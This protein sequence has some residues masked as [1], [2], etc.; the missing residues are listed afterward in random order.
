MFNFYYETYVEDRALVKKFSLK[1]LIYFVF[2]YLCVN[3][4][5]EVFVDTEE[6]G[7]YMAHKYGRKKYIILPVIV[8]DE[9]INSIAADKQKLAGN[10][11]VLYCGK[12][13]P[14]H[15][16]EK[17]IAAAEVLRNEPINFYLQGSGQTRKQ[18]E[19][20]VKT[21]GLGNKVFF[22]DR[23]SYEEM[24]ILMK[25]A[26]V[27]LGVFGSSE[28]TKRV[29]PNKVL[30]ALLCNR[31]VVTLNTNAMKKL[32]GTN[33]LYLINSGELVTTIN[34][35]YKQKIA[36]IQIVVE[37][38]KILSNFGLEAGKKYLQSSLYEN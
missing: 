18:I 35:L 13:I 26:D 38:A 16:V 33:G 23:L 8:D 14:L 5:D 6:H 37:S 9:L 2:D 15:G 1:S 32:E 3:I 34:N 20:L 12:F 22:I 7:Q 30:E 27:C 4:A 11:N 31:P 24:L 28:K 25:A 10:F 21:L 29:V 36:N 17:I 19:V